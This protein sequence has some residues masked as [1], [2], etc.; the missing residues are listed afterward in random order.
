[1]F[2]GGT[3]TLRPSLRFSAPP[4]QFEAPLFSE[5]KMSNSAA[6]IL[7]RVTDVVYWTGAVIAC[8]A[9]VLVSA[10]IPWAVYTRYIRNSAASRPE[11]LAWLLNAAITFIGSADRC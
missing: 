6:G 9:L 10:V 1:M 2:G 3:T 4:K 5:V 7:R 11:P 8:V